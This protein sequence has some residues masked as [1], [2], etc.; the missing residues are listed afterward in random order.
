MASC[1]QEYGSGNARRAEEQLHVQQQTVM[2]LK[3]QLANGTVVVSSTI[4]GHTSGHTENNNRNAVDMGHI[5]QTSSKDEDNHHQH[6][7][8]LQDNHEFNT[9]ANSNNGTNVSGYNTRRSSK[10]DNGLPLDDANHRQLH[11]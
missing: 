11:L 9:N 6:Q 3:M 5:E 8:H 4:N 2:E 7:H 10:E 1:C